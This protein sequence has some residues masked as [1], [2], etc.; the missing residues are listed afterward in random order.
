MSQE[1]LADA[2]DLTFQQI[3]KYERGMNRIGASNLY[4]IS[5]V[6]HVPVSYFFDDMPE[7][8]NETSDRKVVEELFNTRHV[9]RRETINLVRYFYQIPDEATRRN[10]IALME[11]LGEGEGDSP[12]DTGI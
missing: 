4:K 3:Q 6:L 7:D 8:L 11:R 12:E 2:L 1:K 10:I 9:G 5:Q